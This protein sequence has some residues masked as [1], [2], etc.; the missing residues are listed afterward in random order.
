MTTSSPIPS[1]FKFTQKL[2]DQ[3]P[4][5]PKEARATEGEYTDTEVAGLK[6]LVSKS[7]RKF[8]YFRYTLNGQKRAAKLGE[9]G[10]LALAEARKKALELRYQL[11]QGRDPQAEKTQAQAAPSFADFARQ[12]YLPYA[13]QHKRSADSDESK[14]RVHL[15]PRF[16][17]QR[18]DTITTRDI[19]LYHGEIKT[20]RCPGTANRHLS[21][22]SKLFKLAL[23]WERVAK[24]PCQGV[25]KFRENNQRH[26]Y[27]SQEEIQRMFRAMAMEPNQ[28]VVAALK[29][30]L[31]TGLRKEEALQARWAHVDLV[32]GTLFLPDTKSGKSRYV[33]LNPA[34]LALLQE[35]APRDENPFVFPGRI[36]GQALNNPHKGFKRIL[37]AAGIENLRIHDLRHSFASLAVNAGATLYQV[38]HLLGHA[39]AQTTQRYAHLTDGALREASGAVATLVTQATKEDPASKAPA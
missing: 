6:L 31:L 19:Q 26:R 24:N 10:A 36:P 28:I 2:I 23:Q 27:L 3:L 25:K 39:S 12:E 7:G 11:D 29:F 5:H 16:G 38:Q 9:Y 8:F 30:L 1:R 37:A 22:L 20:L 18:L 4:P 35:Q 13:R 21:L 32:R 17:A 15:L 34:A 14:L 33:V